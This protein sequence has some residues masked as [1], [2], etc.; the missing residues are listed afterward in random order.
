MQ[1][2]GI[3]MECCDNDEVSLRLHQALTGAGF[4][5]H[6]DEMEIEYDP[7][8][9]T[10]EE[11][12]LASPKE[13]QAC[14]DTIMADMDQWV[15]IDEAQVGD[16]EKDPKDAD[17]IPAEQYEQLRTKYLDLDCQPTDD[18]PCACIE[19]IKLYEREDPAGPS[20]SFAPVLHKPT[21]S[22]L[23]SNPEFV[24]ATWAKLLKEPSPSPSPL[25]PA[26]INPTPAKRCPIN[27]F[28]PSVYK[29]S[30]LHCPSPNP[31]ASTPTLP[32]YTQ[33][34]IRSLRLLKLRRRWSHLPLSDFTTE[35]RTLVLSLSN[36]SN[37][38]TPWPPL[39]A[40][41]AQYYTK[42]QGVPRNRRFKV[43]MGLLKGLEEGA[44]I[45]VR[46]SKA[47]VKELVG[48]RGEKLIV[49]VWGMVRKGVDD[50]CEV[51]GSLGLGS[52][53]EFTDRVVGGMSGGWSWVD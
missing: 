9:H 1:L 45:K 12:A 46:E 4:A 26:P 37:N 16:E 6:P 10:L 47:A 23:Q 42:M 5:N 31:T 2:A 20:E 30:L 48:A 34:Y 41:L 13:M 7:L 38:L 8:L 50:E 53:P 29:T 14:E 39:A 28:P 3:M 25:R 51:R 36:A 49:G 22:T 17:D 35:L 52:L 24:L 43:K 27:P 19:R 40:W 21:F 18:A 32:F 33:E 11:L 15:P 44:R